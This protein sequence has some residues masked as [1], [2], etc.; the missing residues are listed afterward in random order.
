MLVESKLLIANSLKR[1]FARGQAFFHSVFRP[2]TLGDV[3]AMATYWLGLP[4]ALGSGRQLYHPVH[5][6][7]FCPVVQ[8][9]APHTRR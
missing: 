7:V 5:G 8:I 2:L 6:T 3:R 9:S 1:S 4:S